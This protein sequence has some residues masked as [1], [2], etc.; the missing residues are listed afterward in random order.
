MVHT[1]REHSLVVDILMVMTRTRTEGNHQANSP[2]LS[3]TH[4]HTHLVHR[5]SHTHYT[6][7]RERRMERKSERVGRERPGKEAENQNIHFGSF[8][9]NV[10]C[11]MCCMCSISV[12]M[13][14]SWSV[15]AH[16]PYMF[17][18]NR[19]NSVYECLQLEFYTHTHSYKFWFCSSSILAEK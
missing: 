5:H 13:Y 11:S 16:S 7:H 10:V 17:S 2:I 6:H 9:G 8:W 1:E 4:T 19:K 14:A 12:C 18:S 15:L 3:L